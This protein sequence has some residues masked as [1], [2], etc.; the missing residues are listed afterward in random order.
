MTMTRYGVLFIVLP[1]MGCG[2]FESKSPE[3]FAPPK[4][5]KITDI[6]PVTPSSIVQPIEFQIFA[7]ELPVAKIKDFRDLL[8]S[9]D[10][11]SIEV[12]DPTSFTNNSLGAG[13]GKP[14][15]GTNTVRQLESIGGEQ[16]SARSL[17]VFDDRGD[18]LASVE[19]PQKAEVSWRDGSGVERGQEVG[20]G[21][22]SWILK[23]R[24]AR[25]IRGV[26]EVR[27]EPGFRKKVDE[28]GGRMMGRIDIPIRKFPVGAFSARMGPGDFLLFGPIQSPGNET[29][30]SSLLCRS[31]RNP[32]DR[33][34][35]YLVICTRIAN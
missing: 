18:D 28:I 25:E 20:A 6:Q 12:Q 14:K 5:M 26:A 11:V 29:M 4:G 27:I 24:T 23:S 13:F 2:L 8:Q 21:R 19:L 15:I 10:Q 7:F 22:L 31:L 1:A 33:I 30:L 17:I 34:L 16:V 32:K 35:V 3:P 9:L